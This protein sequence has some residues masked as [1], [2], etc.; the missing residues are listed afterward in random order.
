MN[1]W[2]HR[3]V[4]SVSVRMADQSSRRLKAVRKRLLKSLKAMESVK[5]KT[6]SLL[7]QLNLI[8]ETAVEDVEDCRLRLA[9][10]EKAL[11]AMR[12]ELQVETQVTIPT[13]QKRCKEFE[14]RSEAGI[15]MSN[16]RRAAATPG[17]IDGDM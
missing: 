13:L 15:A 8:S 9:H 16:H 1:F 12:S 4:S 10:S 7:E 6:A 5:K 2:S 3:D 14:A 17:R 11:E